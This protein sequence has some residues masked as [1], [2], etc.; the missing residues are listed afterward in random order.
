MSLTTPILAPQPG[1]FRAKIIQHRRPLL[2]PA[3]RRT[4]SPGPLPSLSSPGRVLPATE[5]AWRLGRMAAPAQP[6]LSP[7]TTLRMPQNSPVPHTQKKKKCQQLCPFCT[8]LPALIPF[9]HFRPNT[10]LHPFPWTPHLDRSAGPLV[11]M[12]MRGQARG[13]LRLP[14]RARVPGGAQKLLRGSFLDL[15]QGSSVF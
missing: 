12:V 13:S 11:A 5:R 10:S 4:L 8:L 15:S 6:A 9:L 1:D 2:P 3:A 14:A 7:P